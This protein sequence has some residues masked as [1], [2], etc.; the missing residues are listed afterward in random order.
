MMIPLAELIRRNI[1]ALCV[2]VVNCVKFYDYDNV[3]CTD[4]L[5]SPPSP[6]I[7][8]STETGE[9]ACTKI[10]TPYEPFTPGSRNFIM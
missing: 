4:F 10:C 3:H 9:E 2:C 7:F 6:Y 1:E 5:L 8:G